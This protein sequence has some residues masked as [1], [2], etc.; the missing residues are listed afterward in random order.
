[1]PF[2]H[3]K[4]NG[5]VGVWFGK[6]Q[7]CGHKWSWKIMLSTKVPDGM[8]FEPVK[9]IEIKKGQTSYAGWGDKFPGVSVVASKL[10]N[11]PRWLRILALV[12]FVGIIIGVILLRGF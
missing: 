8:Y 10:P 2:Y 12:I 5:R 1:M 3:T 11:W 9:K 7:V 6:C 4:D